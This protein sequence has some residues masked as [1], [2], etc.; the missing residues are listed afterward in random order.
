VRCAGRLRLQYRIRLFNGGL[1]V[2]RATH[3]MVLGKRRLLHRQCVEGLGPWEPRSES[4]GGNGGRPGAG[5]VIIHGLRLDPRPQGGILFLD[6]QPL[7]HCRK[8]NLLYLHLICRRRSPIGREGDAYSRGIPARAD[9]RLQRPLQGRPRLY[10]T[11][12]LVG[13]L[14]RFL[15]IFR[16]STRRSGEVMIVD[17]PRDRA[18]RAISLATKNRPY[19]RLVGLKLLCPEPFAGFARERIK[20]FVAQN[21]LAQRGNVQLEQQSRAKKI[22]LMMTLVGR[23]FSANR[24]SVRGAAPFS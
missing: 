24:V 18:G 22:V 3:I 4:L 20:R 11:F 23:F 6:D 17:S 5:S 21:G 15:L 14:G 2:V 10:F 19:N 13:F 7:A 8:K 1:L 12:V 16:T 9:A